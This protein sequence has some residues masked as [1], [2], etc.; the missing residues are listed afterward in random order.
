VSLSV[1]LFLV[2]A[3]LAI[4][5]AIRVV[6]CHRIFHGAMWLIVSFFGV[7]AI[8]M[9]LESP[10]LAGIQLFIYIGGVAVLTVIA[11]MVTKRVMA[12]NQR[13]LND[14]V[15]AGIVALALFGVMVWMILSLPLP[16]APTAPV[17]EGGLEL[18]GAALVDPQGFLLPFEVVSVMMLVVLVASL[19]LGRE[20]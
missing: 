10:F 7:A 3:V 11:I 4:G 5:A 2:F 18:L 20:R 12:P 1:V 9:L 16:M 8:Y 6:F 15:S 13:T 19:Y 17:I 14:P